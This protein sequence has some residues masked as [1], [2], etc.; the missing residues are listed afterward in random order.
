MPATTYDSPTIDSWGLPLILVRLKESFADLVE[1]NPELRIEQTSSGEVVFMTPTGGQTGD[2]NARI[3]SQLVVWADSHD[4]RV[5]DSST[6]FQ[7]PNSAKRSPD[8]SWVSEARWQQLTT[9]QRRGF[10]PLCPDLVIELR[11]ESDRLVDL[12]EKMR[13]YL[14]NGAQLGWLIDP[15]R[16]QVHVY[17]AA[18]APVILDAPASLSG[19]RL[20]PGFTLDLSRILDDG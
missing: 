11:L 7:L 10:P 2:R 12:Q 8:A 3:V 17:Q 20:L 19:D 14:G 4:G 13:E 18:G 9:A 6:L 15:L 5:F 1:L 16:K